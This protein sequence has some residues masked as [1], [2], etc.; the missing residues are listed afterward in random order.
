MTGAPAAS[1]R[2]PAPDPLDAVLAQI[3][4]QLSRPETELEPPRQIGTLEQASLAIA[5]ALDP[6]FRAGVV[7][8]M[9]AERSGEARAL[10]QERLNQ[11]RLGRLTGLFSALSMAEE[12]R[13]KGLEE[14][15]KQADL[16]IAID[17]LFAQILPIQQ[18]GEAAMGQLDPAKPEQT[19]FAAQIRAGIDGL[20]QLRAEYGRTGASVPLLATLKEAVDDM[21]GRID[22]AGKELRAN[23]AFG[24][25]MEAATVA[26][27]RVRTDAVSR[28]LGS[29]RRTRDVLPSLH[30]MVEGTLTSLDK[31]GATDTARQ[32]RGEMEIL[33]RRVDDG[34]GTPTETSAAEA[35]KQEENVRRLLSESNKL[36]LDEAAAQG[37][38]RPLPG[39]TLEDLSGLKTTYDMALSLY[40]AWETLGRPGGFATYMR[41]T[42]AG[43]R[44][45]TPEEIAI[46]AR[47]AALDLPI[48]KEFMGTAVSLMEAQLGKPFF[49]GIGDD[50]RAFEEGLKAK[51]NSL[52]SKGSD[53]VRTFS[54]GGINWDMPSNLRESFDRPPEIP[55]GAKMGGHIYDAKT[56][57][58]GRVYLVPN[59]AGGYDRLLWTP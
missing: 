3:M 38:L 58:M 17:A 26:A 30:G 47:L 21:Q 49:V 2:A 11:G 53:L 20:K 14:S 7:Q 19:A 33:R 10:A 9:I 6:S 35:L 54:T 23:R 59:E 51:I 18:Q 55:E 22:E 40:G 25:Q 39:N 41:K 16:Q 8:P 37:R 32:L 29:L 12:R 46:E 50:P 57:G 45:E 56:R 4:Q 43:Q 44:A 31:M 13:R 28:N 42:I 52:F 48:R 15:G 27:E 1:Q 5:G 36:G 24:D 34:L